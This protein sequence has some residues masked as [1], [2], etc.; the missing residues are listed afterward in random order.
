VARFVTSRFDTNKRARS[1]HWLGCLVSAAT[2][3]FSVILARRKTDWH[4]HKET[5]K[6]YAVTKQKN[7]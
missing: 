6:L 1:T 2:D 4:S 5:I 3:V 7:K